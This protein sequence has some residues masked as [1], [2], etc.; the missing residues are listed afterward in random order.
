MVRHRAQVRVAARAHPSWQAA[1]PAGG[2]RV[3]AMTRWAVRFI[4]EGRAGRAERPRP[5]RR[6]TLP[7]TGRAVL[8]TALTQSPEASGYPLT[9]WTIADRTD[10]RARH[11]GRACAVTVNRMVP[12]RGDV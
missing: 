8:R 6:P 5:G 7:E 11:G 3:R 10:R 9:V 1:A 12:A 2:V 4:A